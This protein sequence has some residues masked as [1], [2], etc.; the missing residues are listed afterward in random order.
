MVLSR[1]CAGWESPTYANTNVR[2]SFSFTVSYAL[3]SGIWGNSVLSGYLME[4]P[5]KNN[6]QVGFAE[7]LQGTVQLLAALPAGRWADQHGRARMLR[8]SA[9]VGFAAIVCFY[10]ALGIGAA[11]DHST[12][13]DG[14]LEFAMM[15]IALGMYG[16]FD[17]MSSGAQD[18]IFHDSVSSEHRVQLTTTV[19]VV[20]VMTRAVGPVFS[21]VLFYWI[22]DT[23]TRPEI[24]T[25]FLIGISLSVLPLWSLFSFRDDA[26]LP[27]QDNQGLMESPVVPGRGGGGIGTGG[28]ARV[29]AGDSEGVLARAASAGAA[30]AALTATATTSE[31]A[32]AREP[33]LQEPLLRQERTILDDGGEGEFAGAS[34]AAAEGE[35]DREARRARTRRA[36]YWVPRIV[37][38][39]DILFGIASGTTV[40][41]FPLFFKTETGLSPAQVNLVFVASPLLIA[42]FSSLAS[43]AV[44]HLGRV[45]VPLI[46][47]AS[48]IVLLLW[49]WWMG[50]V[51]DRAQWREPALVV[52]VFLFRTALMNCSFPIRK[53]I[54]MDF[55]GSDRAWWNSLDSVTRFS[56]SGSAI[57]G[58]LISDKYGYGATF[59]A[60]AA[61][62]LVGLG[63]IAALL[64]W[65]DLI[66]KASAAKK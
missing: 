14:H 12:T 66:V 21:A 41:F 4:I 31:P 6:V 53:S 8:L 2:A 26:C 18:A 20:R 13:N 15:C 49:M 34:A 45:W 56:W 40:K 10:V 37:L 38:T 43:R 46:C 55:V 50:Q 28:D 39:S 47:G 22:G 32:W 24:R 11:L 42:L 30:S 48:G 36:L 17:G 63:A 54:L 29:G 23:W 25:V 7:G 51:N 44:A 19:Y 61:M 33:S 57:I 59:L 58:G 64:P 3:S 35:D 5:P 65:N 62:Q 60:T 27:R 16:L 52:P 1:L 9:A